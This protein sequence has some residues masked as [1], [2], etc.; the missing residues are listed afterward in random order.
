MTP[1]Q[2]NEKKFKEWDELPTGGRRYRLSVPGLHPGWS[3][4]YIKEVNEDEETLL[5]RQEIYNEENEL[6]EVH[7]KYPV[8]T[9]HQKVK[10]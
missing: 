1:R 4:R 5:F 6:V 3:A 10:V 9:G 7:Q 2:R 8:D